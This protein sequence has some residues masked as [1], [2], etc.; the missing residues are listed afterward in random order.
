LLPCTFI[1]L[2]SS[3]SG[4]DEQWIPALQQAL[5][6][7]GNAMKFTLIILTFFVSTQ[8]F[9]QQQS[10][11]T[12]NADTLFIL[13]SLQDTLNTKK[14]VLVEI[15][16]KAT[17]YLNEQLLIQNAV[18]LYNNHHRTDLSAIIRLLDSLSFMK[19]T[20]VI[21]QYFQGFSSLISKQLQIGNA[22]VY[23]K[24]LKL[25][26]P[27]LYHNQ[28]RYGID[29]YRFYYLP[30]RRPFFSI[31]EFP[32]L[33]ESKYFESKKEKEFLTEKLAGIDNR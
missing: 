11:K 28:E 15:G 3:G 5:P 26:V 23:Y 12:D 1:S 20:I 30:D 2:I 7:T 22:K 29:T 13:V 8:L 6:V 25:F 31:R 4:P 24:K 16:E 32:I 27:S 19:D 33:K 17:I 14:I 18:E 21:D 9:A 10:D